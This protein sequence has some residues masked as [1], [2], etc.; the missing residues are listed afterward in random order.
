MQDI[1][2]APQRTGLDRELA[3]E[4]VRFLADRALW[5]PR[6]RTLFVADVHL[7]KAESFRALGVPMPSGPTRTTLERLSQL[8][9]AC[10]AVHL[11]VLGDLLH[12]RAAQS[13]AVMRPLGDWR[14]AHADLRIS[15]V[16]GNHDQHAGDPP[17]GLGIE[18]V[19]APHAM[20]PFDLCHDDSDAPATTQAHGPAQARTGYRLEGH[21]HPAVRCAVRAGR[22]LRL[23]CFCIGPNRT[24]LPAFGDFTGTALI[25]P[26]A[27]ESVLAIAEDMLIALPPGAVTPGR[28]PLSAARAF[29]R[30][31]NRR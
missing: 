12:A 22:S 3:G 2:P 19:D 21:V 14:G 9:R 20:G 1:A 11:V 26:E 28:R 7:G 8:V 25:R 31:G 15:L 30:S 16:R 27:D 29:P 18:V 17:A 6:E 5:W 24:L 13:D 10:L 4:S 23:P